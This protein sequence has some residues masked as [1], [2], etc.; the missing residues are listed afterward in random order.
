MQLRSG[1]FASRVVITFKAPN[2][3]LLLSH[4]SV[5][6]DTHFPDSQG[7]RLVLAGTDLLFD[8]CMRRHEVYFGHSRFALAWS[9]AYR[10]DMFAQLWPVFARLVLLDLALDFG[11]H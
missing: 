2:F 7:A 8:M 11:S 6:L 5:Y 3:R 4:L 9:L 10:L 1:T